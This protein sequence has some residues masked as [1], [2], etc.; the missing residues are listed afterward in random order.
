MIDDVSVH[1]PTMLKSESSEQNL[2]L[3]DLERILALGS[4]CDVEM[5]LEEMTALLAG[6]QRTSCVNCKRDD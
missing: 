3:E 1:E 5:S 6:V 2:E 4:V